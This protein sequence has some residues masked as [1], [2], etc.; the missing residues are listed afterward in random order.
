MEDGRA[1]VIPFAPPQGLSFAK[2]AISGP[3]TEQILPVMIA[4][5]ESLAA[6]HEQGVVHRSLRPD[7]VWWESSTGQVRF[8]DFVIARI[9][10][11]ET[12]VARANE[13]DIDHPYRSAECRIDLATASPKSDVYSL[14]A[15]MLNWI[16]GQSPPLDDIWQQSHWVILAKI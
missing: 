9:D 3:A 14:A 13:F 1:L 15:I 2:L 12:V 6:V 10:G 4:A 7:R 11:M 16:T 5:F 8:S